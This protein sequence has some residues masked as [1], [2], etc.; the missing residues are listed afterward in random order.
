MQRAKMCSLSKLADVDDDL[1]VL[2]IEF[3]IAAVN[4]SVQN[5]HYRPAARAI[6]RKYADRGS[7]GSEFLYDISEGTPT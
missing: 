3:V 1:Q 6:L 7:C 2:E 4:T 5:R